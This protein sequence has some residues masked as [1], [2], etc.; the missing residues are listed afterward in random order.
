MGR[1]WIRPVR[2]STAVFGSSFWQQFLVV[3]QDELLQT[4]TFPDLETR[5]LLL[6]STVSLENSLVPHT[7]PSGTEGSCGKNCGN[8]RAVQGQPRPTAEG[9]CPKPVPGLPLPPVWVLEY[10]LIQGAL[11]SALWRR[12]ARWW[13]LGTER[14]LGPWGIPHHL[15]LWFLFLAEL[16]SLCVGSVPLRRDGTR[17]LGSESA[18]S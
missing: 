8:S 12:R 3:M 9:T 14:P 10:L 1:G 6:H 16:S 5:A 15:H 7:V 2:L 18:E 11:P 17:A 13:G 4:R